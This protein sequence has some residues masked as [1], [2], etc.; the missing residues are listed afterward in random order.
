MPPEFLMWAFSQVFAS[1]L[2]PSA[3]DH[4]HE[5]GDHRQGEQAGDGVAE[6]QA[7]LAGRCGGTLGGEPLRAQTLLLF[8]ATGHAGSEEA[9]GWDSSLASP[10]AVPGRRRRRLAVARRIGVCS[11][12]DVVEESGELAVE[13]VGLIRHSRIEFASISLALGSSSASMPESEKG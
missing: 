1:A 3:H 2:L 4:D 5:P 9:S 7:P 10:A 12:P 6:D 13:A 11:S 8:L